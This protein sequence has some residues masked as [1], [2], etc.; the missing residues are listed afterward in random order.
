MVQHKEKN[1][2]SEQIENHKLATDQ[3]V[4][5]TRKR[6]RERKGE[7]SRSQK[8]E[9]EEEEETKDGEEKGKER[10]EKICKST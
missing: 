9:E 1:N 3:Y 10:E 6:G 5:M 7:E 2:M 4:V 8:E